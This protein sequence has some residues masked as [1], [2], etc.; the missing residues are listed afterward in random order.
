[1]RNS[2]GF[3]RH[4]PYHM[5]L[6]D[7]PVSTSDTT[8]NPKHSPK[9]CWN[10]TE[11]A[12]YRSAVAD[13]AEENPEVAATPETPFEFNEQKLRLESITHQVYTDCR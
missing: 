12:P 10:G 8:A 5:C 3:W 7:G 13:D 6:S 4:L 1:V 9:S 11:P 2:Q